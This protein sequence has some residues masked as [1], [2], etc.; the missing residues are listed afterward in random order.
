MRSALGNRG[1]GRGGRG[2][3][4]GRF[5]SANY[6]KTNERSN[7]MMFYPHGTGKQ[8]QTNTYESVKEHIVQYVQKTYRYGHDIAR[9]LR[10][11]REIDLDQEAPVRKISTKA[12][13]DKALE[14][15]GMDMKKY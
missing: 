4:R 9:S 13:N 1:R 11:L 8:Q 2:R 12:D 14:Q 5:T 10:D 6:K 7:E 3:G 15:E